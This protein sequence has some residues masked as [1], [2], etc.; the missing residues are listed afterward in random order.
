MAHHKGRRSKN[1]RAGCLLCKPWKI[2]G[3]RQGRPEAESSSDHCR[4]V[5]LMASCNSYGGELSRK[6][7]IDI[8]AFFARQISPVPYLILY[9]N[10]RP[11]WTVLYISPAGLMGAVHS[12]TA[13]LSSYPLPGETLDLKR[14]RSR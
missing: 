6:D 12:T 7:G 2:N 4:A 9:S 10:E 1:Q 3:F 13:A 14:S 8:T 11:G 5:A